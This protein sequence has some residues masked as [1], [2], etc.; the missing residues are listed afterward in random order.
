MEMTEGFA[1]T[2]A[3][4]APV[5]ILVGAV[6]L[7]FYVKTHKETNRERHPGHFRGPGDIAGPLKNVQL[8]VRSVGAALSGLIWCAFMI[9]L[10]WAEAKSLAWLADPAAPKNSGDAEFCLIALNVGLAWVALVPVLRM[11]R[12]LIA[13]FLEAKLQREEYERERERML[14]AGRVPRLRGEEQP[15]QSGQTGLAE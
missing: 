5:I 12:R 4:V 11:I 6:E 3:A 15:R 9:A 14:R 8:A 13:G 2:V 1:A 7:G 10:C